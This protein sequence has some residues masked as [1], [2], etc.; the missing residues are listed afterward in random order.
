MTVGTA[1]EGRDLTYAEIL[2]KESHFLLFYLLRGEIDPQMYH[3]PN[4]HAY[5]GVRSLLSDLHDTAIR[6]FRRHSRLPIVSPDMDVAGKRIADTMARNASNI[7]G[8]VGGA[9]AVIAMMSTI[10]PC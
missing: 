8:R 2:D 5:D 1:P 3:Q 7:V 6:K 10:T 4:V 9:H